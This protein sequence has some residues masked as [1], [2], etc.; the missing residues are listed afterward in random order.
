M[1]RRIFYAK[2]RAH[3]DVFG[4]FGGRYMK[5]HV[6][7]TPKEPKAENLYEK[8]SAFWFFAL[9]HRFLCEKSSTIGRSRGHIL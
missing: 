8:S 7:L 3:F 1:D 5:F 6:D 2:N 9:R 4:D